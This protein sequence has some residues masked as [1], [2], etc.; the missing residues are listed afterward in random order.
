MKRFRLDRRVGGRVAP[1]VMPLALVLAAGSC[2]DPGGSVDPTAVASSAHFPA[3]YAL[4]L[5]RHNRDPADFVATF[6][7]GGLQ[8]QTGPAGSSIGPI[9]WSTLE[10]TRCVLG[11]PRSV[12]PSGIEKASGCSLA[13][14]ICR[15]PTS[16]TPTSW[17]AA[18]DATSSDTGTA[19]PLGRCRTDGSRPKPCGPPPGRA[20]I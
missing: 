10:A 18:T 7:D 13:V 20:A 4:R 19:P 14:R 1:R 17:S 15:A 11:S 2:G 5:D 3:G 6:N 8:V 16:G 12:R 9:R